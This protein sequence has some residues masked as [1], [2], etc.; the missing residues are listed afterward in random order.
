MIKVSKAQSKV[1]HRIA[2]RDSG[3][4]EADSVAWIT[5]E[6]LLKKKLIEECVRLYFGPRT[7]RYRLTQAGKDW[8]KAHP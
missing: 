7:Q 6:C 8:V 4:I 1:L 5:S 3:A 2:E